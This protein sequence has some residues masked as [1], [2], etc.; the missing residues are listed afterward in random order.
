MKK[1][2]FVPLLI[3]S[4]AVLCGA[5]SKFN[6]LKTAFRVYPKDPA[7]TLQNKVNGSNR[8]MTFTVGT[9][10]AMSSLYAYAPV[11]AGK[12]Y[13]ISFLYK[14]SDLQK[15]QGKRSFACIRINFQ[16]KKGLEVKSAPAVKFDL[17]L[18]N[19]DGKT[20]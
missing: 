1:L 3:F 11:E 13:M 14:L 2:L 12:K 17:D 5:E 4:A 15:A 10:K 8:V 19:T 20:A 16:N 9:P 18:K 7:I 6:Y